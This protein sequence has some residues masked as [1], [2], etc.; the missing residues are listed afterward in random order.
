[1]YYL[2]ENVN[3]SAPGKH[4]PAA[5]D[6]PACIRWSG[7]YAAGFFYLKARPMQE[8]EIYDRLLELYRLKDIYRARA[9]AELENLKKTTRQIRELENLLHPK[10]N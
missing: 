2:W 3:I 9:R 8:K 7:D 6:A 5:T 10:E 1:M 4:F